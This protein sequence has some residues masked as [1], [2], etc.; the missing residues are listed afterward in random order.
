M[1]FFA[2]V[3]AL[4]SALASTAAAKAPS[5]DGPVAVM[6]F[7]NLS[8]AP[9]LAWLEVGIAE[10]MIADLRRGQVA[11]VERAQI[12]RALKELA[13][14]QT[15][16]IDPAS[17]AKL[18]KLVGAH[19]IVVGA[20][21]EAAHRLRLTARFVAV[22]SGVVQEA[23]SATGPVENIFA[24]QDE[25]VDKLLGQPPAARPPRKSTPKMVEAYQ[26]YSHAL[27]ASADGDRA[28]LLT[29][30]VA[31]DPSFVYAADDLA[32]LQKRMAEY[33]RTSSLKLAER[34]KALWT[35][36]QNKKLSADDRLRTARELLE[37]LAAARR[38][39]TLADL[40]AKMSALKLEGLDEEASFRRF[41]ALDKLKAHDLALQLGEQH[42]K[43]FPSGLRYREVETRMHEIVEARRKLI[44]R[45]PEYESDLKEKRDGILDK[46]VVPPRK[47]VEYDFAPCI[48]TRWN[49]LTTDLMLDNCSKYLEQHGGDADPDAQKHALAA[50]FFVVLAL[51][52]KGEFERARPLAE[53]LIADSDEWDE[54]LR[55]L[56]SEWPTD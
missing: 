25:L 44:S 32:A 35:R 12:D 54:E 36:A 23:A 33:S 28:I 10:T 1:R 18:G 55:K 13:L 26:I 41:T 51:D 53:K 21:Q 34:E 50:R 17:A 15:G 46:G 27:L 4:S 3:M 9:K 22:E 16:A 45:R 40:S 7:A 2:L 42:L 49:S 24:L 30:A 47:R 8:G 29:R 20:V 38:W 11:V 43:S 37:S 6:P 31:A 19:T 14:Q 5:V 56:M 39:H 48:A 52:A